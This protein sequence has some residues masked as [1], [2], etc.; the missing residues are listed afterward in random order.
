MFAS[1]PRCKAAKQR[2]YCSVL[3]LGLRARHPSPSCK[4]GPGQA[5]GGRRPPSC[6]GPSVDPSLDSLRLLLPGGLEW[7]CCSQRPMG[8]EEARLLAAAAPPTSPD[9]TGNFDELPGV[10]QPRRQM[11][12]S[13]RGGWLDAI[14]CRRGGGQEGMCANPSSGGGGGLA[15]PLPTSAP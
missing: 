10:W 15:Q 7:G 11:V 14:A 8:A 5:A 1:P 4:E 6:P 2:S 12:R 9:V 13:S 3:L